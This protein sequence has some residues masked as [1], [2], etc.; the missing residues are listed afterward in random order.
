MTIEDWC[1][2]AYA[3]KYDLP[4]R[5]GP[6]MDELVLRA[7]VD[8]DGKVVQDEIK[9]LTPISRRCVVSLTNLNFLQ[10]IAEQ[11]EQPSQ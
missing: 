2:M 11:Q 3:T 4:N 6:G 7:A 9:R 10:R 1:Q 5:F 8:L